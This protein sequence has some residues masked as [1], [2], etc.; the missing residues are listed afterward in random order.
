[1]GNTLSGKH[2]I[3][4]ATRKTEEMSKLI[5]KQGGTASVRSLQ[6]T[7]YK[8]DDEV[9]HDLK[10]ICRNRCGLVYFHNRNRISNSDRTSGRY[11]NER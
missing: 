4:G 11:R 6:G 10:R 7:V 1:M 5:E 2:I 3:L 8:A 9:K